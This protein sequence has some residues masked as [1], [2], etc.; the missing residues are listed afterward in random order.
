[1]R[2]RSGFTITELLVAMALIVF[3]MSI[4]ATAFS[5]GAK[6]FRTLKAIGDMNQRLRIVSSQLRSD[7]EANHFEGDRRLSDANFWLIGPPHDGFF[8]IWQGSRI[9]TGT[10]YVSEGTDIDYGI[11]SVRATD[12]ILHMTVKKRGNNPK[13][14]FRGVVPRNFPTGA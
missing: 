8:R 1:M 14:Y 9:N 13:D 10:G 11:E 7:L 6:T 12:H 2:R 3:I 5:E 4:L